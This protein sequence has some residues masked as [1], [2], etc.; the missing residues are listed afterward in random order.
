M[1]EK[2]NE[3]QQQ[4]N[5][6]IESAQTITKN[7]K[8]KARKACEIETTLPPSGMQSFLANVSEDLKHLG[9]FY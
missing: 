6:S 9:K 1:E 7:A 4:S 8:K 3:L 2:Y 5:Q